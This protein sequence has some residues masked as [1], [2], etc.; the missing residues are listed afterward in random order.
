MYV[1]RPVSC[2]KVHRKTS[3]VADSLYVSCKERN[4]E[5]RVAL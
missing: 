2:S 5:T 4:K 3:V 1:S